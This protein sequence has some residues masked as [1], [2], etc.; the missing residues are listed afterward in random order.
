[1]KTNIEKAVGGNP[2]RSNCDPYI[3]VKWF[4]EDGWTSS[5]TM[6]DL[7]HAAEAMRLLREYLEAHERI[8]T[9]FTILPD[10]PWGK[11]LARDREMRGEA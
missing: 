11:W 10:G 5:L 8:I 9:S 3:T 4:G 6:G 2:G 7:R 1:M